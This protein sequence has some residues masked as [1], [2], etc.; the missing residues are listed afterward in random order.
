MR[1]VSYPEH[2]VPRELRAQMVALQNQAWPSDGP[3]T[4]APRHDGALDP[5]SALLVDDDV[6]VLSAID[7]LSKPIDHAGRSFDASGISAMVTDERRRGEGFGR[8]LARAALT[9]MREAGADLGIFTCDRHLQGFYEGA[10][11]EYLPGTVLVGGTPQDPFPS[12]RFDKVTMA[13]FFSAQAN[14]ARERFVEARVEL[15]PGDIDK[16]W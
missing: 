6:R 8:A 5:V 1:V 2:A 7:I 3:P 14:A 12:D 10:G 13:S 11:W 9:I 4:L 15:F 16:L